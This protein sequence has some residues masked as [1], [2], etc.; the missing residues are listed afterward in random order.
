[1]FLDL[2]IAGTNPLATDL[3]AADIMGFQT[4]EIPT[5]EWAVQSGMKPS[6]LSDIEVRGEK[7]A[8]VRKNFKK[9]QV[10]KWTDINKLWGFEEI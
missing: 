5:F 3:V 4:G 2:I 7:L 9:P 10:R 6:K 8:N 1:M